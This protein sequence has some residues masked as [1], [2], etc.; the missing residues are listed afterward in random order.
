MKLPRKAVGDMIP[1]RLATNME[2][3]DS[4]NG[5]VKSTTASR[6]A[7]IFREVRTMSNFLATSAAIN[8]FHFPFYRK[9]RNNKSRR[10][11]L[12]TCQ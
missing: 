11:I 3:P 6:S 1:V 4:R 2:V 5:A 7:F 9:R 10:V 8:P 12:V